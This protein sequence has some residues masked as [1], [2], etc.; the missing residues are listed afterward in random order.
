MSAIPPDASEKL[1]TT[2][3]LFEAGRDLMRQNLRRA[4]SEASEAEITRRLN[5]WLRERPGAEDG[6]AAGRRV[7]WPRPGP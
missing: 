2:F 6:D 1:R 7:P 3:D 4:Y 5:A